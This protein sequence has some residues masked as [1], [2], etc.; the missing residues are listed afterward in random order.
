MMNPSTKLTRNITAILGFLVKAE[1][2]AIFKQQP[3]EL[4]DSD[5]DPFGA[6]RT[7]CDSMRKLRPTPTDLNIGFLDEKSLPI[8]REI[9]SRPTFARYYEAVDDYQFALLPIQG[10][11]TPQW[12]A[13]LDYI[14][15]LSSRFDEPASLETLLRFTMSEGQVAD[16]I[17]CG[18]QVIFNSLRPDLLAEPVPAVERKG[19][20]QFE[21][22]V[23]AGSRPNY[24]QVAAIGSR[25]LL[26]NGVHR[27]CALHLSGHTHVPCLLRKV[28]RIEE[29]GIAVQTSLLRPEL[30]AG[31]RPA[32]VADFLNPKVAT[33]LKMRSTEHVLRVAIAVEQIRIPAISDPTLDTER[34]AEESFRNPSPL[35]GGPG[36]HTTAAI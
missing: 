24:V 12:F 27:V 23:R 28:G 29:S 2:D 7:S 33:N 16:P 26:T 21:I 9:K 10:L 22:T 36:E 3:F 1:V 30:L 4:A 25:F 20:G 34:T 15:E 5:S 13:D 19:P 31:P 8:I 6:W 32:E 35:Q 11:L 17:I 14:N 18:S